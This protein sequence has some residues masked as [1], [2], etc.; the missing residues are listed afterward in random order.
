MMA[1]PATTQSDET[2]AADL[3]DIDVVAWS[4]QQAVLLREAANGRRSH[5][6][7]WPNVIEEIESVGREQVHAVEGLLLQAVVHEL[8]A[9][10]WPETSY[11]E[12]WLADARMFRAQAALR[13][14]SSMRRR[15]DLSGLVEKAQ[16][17]LPRTVDGA[18]PGLI[19]SA[20]TAAIIATI[21]AEVLNG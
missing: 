5:D 16:R 13:F 10:C 6:V 12:K 19:A 15:I 14:T 18:Q 11:V 21:K 3:Y 9:E 2:V 20:W 1:R 4:E 17:A 8:K 7:D